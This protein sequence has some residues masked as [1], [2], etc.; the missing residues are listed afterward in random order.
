MVRHKNSKYSP[1]V[2]LCMAES[3]GGLPISSLT[4]RIYPLPAFENAS[5]HPASA[6]DSPS[7]ARSRKS[8]PVERPMQ[9]TNSLK[10]I[11]RPAWNTH[12]INGL[13]ISYSSSRTGRFPSRKNP[14]WAFREIERSAGGKQLEADRAQPLV[15]T[16]RRPTCQFTNRP[17]LELFPD[18]TH[19]RAPSRRGREHRS[20]S[21]R[22]RRRSARSSPRS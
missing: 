14:D 5:S 12:N 11:C 3:Y 19:P 21:R 22:R 17:V 6:R 18:P 20:R 9:C 2:R 4:L 1:R 13:L 15:Y 10:E 7:R 8:R 16:E